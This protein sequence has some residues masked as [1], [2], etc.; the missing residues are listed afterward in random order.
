MIEKHSLALCFFCC[1]RIEGTF[2]TDKENRLKFSRTTKKTTESVVFSKIFLD[3][4]EYSMI[5]YIQEV[6]TRGLLCQ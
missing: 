3:I 5:L 6:T 2:F 4:I 1:E